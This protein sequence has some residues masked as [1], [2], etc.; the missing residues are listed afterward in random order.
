LP[1]ELAEFGFEAF[2]EEEDGKLSAF[3]PSRSF[4][5]MPVANFLEERS[6]SM[7]FSY[8]VTRI[9]ARNWNAVWESE[10]DPVFISGRCMIR[11]PFHPPHPDALFDLVIEPK[12]SFGT[13][14][15]ETT[16]LMIETVLETNIRSRKVLD[17]GCGT[18]VLAILAFKMGAA[19]VVAVDNDEWAFANAIENTARNNTGEIIVIKGDASAV[20]EGDFDIIMANIN[21]NV[22]LGDL[23]AYQVLLARG[24]VLIL[25]GFY[26][27][28]LQ[29][30]IEKASSLDLHSTGFREL[31]KWVVATFTK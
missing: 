12:M 28:D 3:I 5:E 21:R 9:P 4:D 31:N 29:A 20:K 19:G 2:S 7:G 17:M 24:G 10:Y 16:R 22:L 14:H 23:P 8:Q 1:A 18:G 26:T 27:A 6:S 30:I 13:A 15:H 11:A 25:S